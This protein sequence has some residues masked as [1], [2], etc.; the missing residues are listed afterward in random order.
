MVSLHS[1]RRSV[2]SWWRAS[3]SAL[4]AAAL[5][6]AGCS[7]SDAP[8][9]GERPATILDVAF[10]EIEGSET[11]EGIGALRLG[12]GNC[13]TLAGEESAV[14]LVVPADTVIDGDLLRFA[15]GREV[16]FGEEAT[17]G[18]GYADVEQE[19]FNESTRACGQSLGLS[20]AF[21]TTGE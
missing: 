20:E 21:T 5:V 14:L 7:D 6:L 8:E 9:E 13:L 3:L 10:D 16:R 4:A 12:E 19:S 11:A 18:G 17:F 2:G 15:H 1:Q